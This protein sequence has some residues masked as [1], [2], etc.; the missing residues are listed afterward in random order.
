[1]KRAALIKSVI[2]IVDEELQKKENEKNELSKSIHS[3]IGDQE[4]I[5]AELR[6]NAKK[7]LETAQNQLNKYKD[8]VN[9][10]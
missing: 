8:E 3:S 5:S 10:V 9:K 4:T 6:N 2:E 1:M 7:R